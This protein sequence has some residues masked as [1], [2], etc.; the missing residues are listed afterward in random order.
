MFTAE[1][2]DEVFV[3]VF[4]QVARGS[5]DSETIA[6]ITAMGEE[7]TARDDLEF[8]L[9]CP[10]KREWWRLVHTPEGGLLGFAIPSRTPYGPN[11]GHLGVI[12]EMRGRRHIDD[13][14]THITRFH[15]GE[16]AQRITATTA[17]ANAPMANAFLRGGYRV[18]EIRVILAAPTA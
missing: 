8:Y 15:A 9:G 18:S 16:G 10:G 3:D 14:L 6:D 2:D 4:R 12:P 1:P 11:V 17:A 7:G 13:I 5:L